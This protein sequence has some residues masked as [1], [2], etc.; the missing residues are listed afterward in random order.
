MGAPPHVVS[1][2]CWVGDLARVDDATEEA[3]FCCLQ[4]W[5][6]AC[7]FTS[8]DGLDEDPPHSSPARPWKNVDIIFHVIEVTNN[9]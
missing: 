7:F 1:S 8:F 6:S 4:M 5:Q 3:P 2:A 9:G